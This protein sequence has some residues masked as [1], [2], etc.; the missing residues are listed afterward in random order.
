M[1]L[2]AGYELA[3]SVVCDCLSS[4]V[5]AWARAQ[6]HAARAVTSH[7]LQVTYTLKHVESYELVTLALDWSLASLKHMLRASVAL[8]QQLL[9][10]ALGPGQDIPLL[11]MPSVHICAICTISNDPARVTLA[12]LGHRY[13]H[14]SLHRFNLTS[15]TQR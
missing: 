1:Q 13:S 8:T 4:D 7:K 11:P 3:L 14:C 2:V 9:Q 10:S 6:R 15:S 5:N 12:D